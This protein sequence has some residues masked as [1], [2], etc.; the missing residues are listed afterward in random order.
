MNNKKRYVQV[1]LGG[2][3]VFFFGAIA[4]KYNETSE[5]CDDSSLKIELPR[6]VRRRGFAN[7]KNIFFFGNFYCTV[8]P[9]I[10]NPL[11]R[12]LIAAL[13][14]RSWCVWQCGQSQFRILRFF[15]PLIF[16]FRFWQLL[17]I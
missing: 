11:F 13:R 2:R 3:A 9:T 6:R 1:G 4:G 5:K 7:Q 15:S 10:S 17:Q 8:V 14:S 16:L 12:M